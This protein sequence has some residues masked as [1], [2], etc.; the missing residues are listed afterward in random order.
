M[1]KQYIKNNDTTLT[2]E[3]WDIVKPNYKLT[4]E[5]AYKLSNGD[6]ELLKNLLPTE[7][8]HFENRL[9]DLKIEKQLHERLNGSPFHYALM[10]RGINL[11][12]I[13]AD[14]IKTGQ[15]SDE[16]F[17]MLITICFSPKDE[18]TIASLEQL[19]ITKRNK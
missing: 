17:K 12:K 19:C 1:S 13:V 4:A 5:E 16:F 6:P 3:E 10:R 11:S 18:K 7:K 15:M 8:K 9:W 2:Q 14:K